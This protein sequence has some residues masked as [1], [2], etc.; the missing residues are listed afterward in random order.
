MKIDFCIP[1]RNE[2]LTLED[3]LLKLKNY[4]ESLN[5]AGDWQIVGANNGSS[6]SSLDILRRLQA[7]FPQRFSFSDILEP[8]KGRAIKTCWRESRADIL[9]FMDADL[10]VDLSGVR[11]LVEPLLLNQADLVVGSRFMP[12]ATAK[13]SWQRG[14]ISKG[15]ALF[16]QFL[17]GHDKS[18]LQCG[19]KAISRRAFKRIE[20]YLEDDTW[21]LDT[22][23][24]MIAA[25]SGNRILEI[26]V[27]WQENRH[28]KNKSNVNVFREGWSFL[29]KTIKLKRRLKKVKKY[30]KN[31]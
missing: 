28:G 31:V 14:L 15:Y 20:A 4:L 16:S 19:F 17:L 29:L 8:G 9:V 22:E 3:N 10:A 11:T 21:F 5:L 25:L 13:R 7:Q 1:I 12:G 27:I 24:L 2:A 30:L 26:P 23:L 18:D 6:D